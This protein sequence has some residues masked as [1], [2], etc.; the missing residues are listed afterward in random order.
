[1][2][3][4]SIPSS[5]DSIAAHPF[6]CPL[7]GNA[8]HESQ[9]LSLGRPSGRATSGHTKVL[10]MFWPPIVPLSR[11]R[12]G[13]ARDEARTWPKSASTLPFRR[14]STFSRAP[15]CSAHRSMRRPSSGW[16]ARPNSANR[17]FCCAPEMAGRRCGASIP[18]RYCARRTK[19]R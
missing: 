2:L 9:A 3:G 8:V 14:K 13:E 7:K 1:M 10:A 16:A 15:V 19:A 12:Q 11:P 5:S 6:A 4:C 17:A 18:P